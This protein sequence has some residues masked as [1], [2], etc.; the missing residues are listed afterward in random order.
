MGIEGVIDRVT[1]ECIDGWVYR[2]DNPSEHLIVTVQFRGMNIGSD[3]ASQFR[4]DLKEANIG[5]GDHAYAV[6][7]EQRIEAH[8][9]AELIVLARSRDGEHLELP[10]PALPDP[11]AENNT[12][13]AQDPENTTHVSDAVIRYKPVAGKA[14]PPLDYR[15]FS[16]IRV[17]AFKHSLPGFPGGPVLLEPEFAQFRHKQ[18]DRTVDSFDEKTHFTRYLEGDW[19]YIG[20]TYPHFGH[21][22][23]E[24]IHRILPSRIFFPDVNRYLLVTTLNH[25]VGPGIESLY[26][27]HQEV[28]EFC[29]IDPGSVLI[30]NENAVVEHLSICEQ[31]ATLLGR[32]TPWYLEVL[33]DFSTRRLDQI[34]GSRPSPAQVYVSKSKIPHGSTI[35]GERY[36]E[37]LL[38]HEGFFIFHP[39]E[40]PLSLQMDIYRKAKQ[41]VFAEGSAIHGTQLLGEKMLDSTFVFLRNIH[42][43][44]LLADILQPRSQQLDMFPDTSILGTIIVDR[45][46]R[47]PRVEFSVSLFDIDRLVTFFHDHQLA[48]LSGIDVGQYFDA[49]EQDLK[50]YFSFHMDSGIDDATAVVDAWRI[51]EVRL[52]FEKNRQRFLGNR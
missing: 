1:S 11:E 18:G 34:H 12:E 27:T 15:T 48:R 16:N 19:V 6:F 4:E 25:E 21:I 2:D 41:L 8:E 49:A 46:S 39:E 45:D 14:H 40:A 23:A 26:R 47:R 35:L 3:S 31:G 10:L 20:S 7:L 9:F 36:I 50:A 29:E 30:L 38:S 13:A 17:Q 33:Q 5:A 51:G 43:Q 24:M 42:F 28:L 32:P 37:E 52:E 22:M 44:H